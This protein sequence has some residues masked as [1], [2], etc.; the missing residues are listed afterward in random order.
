[1]T[2][3]IEFISLGMIYAGDLMLCIC[4]VTFLWLVSQEGGLE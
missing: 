1:M 4:A 2:A 3:A